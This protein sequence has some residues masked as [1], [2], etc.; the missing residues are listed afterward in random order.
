MSS[1]HCFK[2]RYPPPYSREVW[3]FKEANTDL[4][5]RALND[6]NWERAFSNANVNEKLSIFNKS[7][8]N[9]L[10]NFIPHETILCDDKDP[11]WFNSRIKSFLHGKNKIFKN[12]RKNKTN[13][14]LLNK[15]NFAQE[16][17]NGLITLSKNN[18][19]ERM[20]KKLNNLQRNSKAYWSLL[21]C[22][23]NNKKIPLIPPLFYEN[24]FVTNFLE[25]AEV[26]NSFFSVFPN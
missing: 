25:K 3:H 5:R 13:L 21:R 4:I 9:V 11:P 20:V 19:Y 8:L 22:L 17:L 26:F 7:V 23:L 24:K 12:Y 6:F 15:L 14:Q 1:S 16:Q 18:D 10:S 2:I